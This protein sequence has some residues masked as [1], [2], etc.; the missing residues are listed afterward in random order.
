MDYVQIL[1]AS[2]L[3]QLNTGKIMLAWLKLKSFLI[4]MFL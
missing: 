2:P 4:F 1:K 3:N